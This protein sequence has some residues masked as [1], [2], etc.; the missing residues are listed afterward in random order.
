MATTPVNKPGLGAVYCPAGGSAGPLAVAGG[1]IGKASPPATLLMPG[2]NGRGVFSPEHAALAASTPHTIEYNGPLNRDSADVL[3]TGFVDAVSAHGPERTYALAVTV[4]GESLSDEGCIVDFLRQVSTLGGVMRIVM[5]VHLS[6]AFPR[7]TIMADPTN[8]DAIA[9]RV[10]TEWRELATM[11]IHDAPRG[12]EELIFDQT[13]AEREGGRGRVE[14]ALRIYKGG[15]DSLYKSI[16]DVTSDDMKGLPVSA[17][18]EK[19]ICALRHR[20]N[21]IAARLLALSIIIGNRLE[22]DDKITPKVNA[23]LPPHDFPSLWVALQMAGNEEGG[24]RGVTV[25]A[26]QPPQ[27]IILRDRPGWNVRSQILLLDEVLSELLKNA[28][29]YATTTVRLEWRLLPNGD[30]IIRVEN[31]VSSPL[32]RDAVKRLGNVGAMIPGFK[33]EDSSHTGLFTVVQMLDSVGLPPPEF[34]AEKDD[35]KER[36]V[37]QVVIP[38]ERLSDAEARDGWGA[39]PALL[40]EPLRVAYRA[41]KQWNEYL[42]RDTT[43]ASSTS[44]E[45]WVSSI[46][47]RNALLLDP[48]HF[49][50]N[51]ISGLVFWESLEYPGSMEPADA[52]TIQHSAMTLKA[53]LGIFSGDREAGDALLERYVLPAVHPVVTLENFAAGVT[54]LDR[55]LRDVAK[56]PDDAVNESVWEDAIAAMRA[57]VKEPVGVIDE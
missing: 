6:L 40:R 34:R 39:L 44:A 36:F 49:L 32:N 53:F 26:E 11:L 42:A 16:G 21:N 9:L 27:G 47:L 18:T 30:L 37:A 4:A 52:N 14:H 8:A 12:L 20:L 10:C 24:R 50:G 23:L 17:D 31:D 48:S 56:L 22:N 15:L 45:E 5:S 41:F 55:Y 46:G 57:R 19:I 43:L 29:G 3:L 51:T 33:R 38:H 1:P 35:D 28:V 54:L 13:L 25:T 2:P 7:D